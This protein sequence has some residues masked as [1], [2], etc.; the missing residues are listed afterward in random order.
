M[1]AGP[2]AP[3]L[4]AF[5]DY[6]YNIIVCIIIIMIIITIIISGSSSSSGS[7]SGSGSGSS[8]SSSCCCCSSSSSRILYHSIV[9]YNVLI[10]FTACDCG[11][12]RARPRH[13]LLVPMYMYTCIISIYIYIRR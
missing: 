8:S 10:L 1:Q 5:A 12:P 13:R 2:V 6:Y 11:P 4:F 7:G 9:Y 3:G